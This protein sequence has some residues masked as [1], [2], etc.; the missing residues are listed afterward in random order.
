MAPTT[1]STD[2][3]DGH[4]SESGLNGA[5]NVNPAGNDA[6]KMNTEPVKSPQLIPKLTVVT[7]NQATPPTVETKLD[8]M[9]D[10]MNKLTET[11]NSVSLQFHAVKLEIVQLNNTVADIHKNQAD[12]AILEKK[13]NDIT[14][15]IEFN[16]ADRNA[17]KDHIKTIEQ[18][19]KAD[20]I[21]INQLKSNVQQ[22]PKVCECSKRL[23]RLE[24]EQKRK[25]ILITG[26]RERKGE[27]LKGLV[28]EILSNT[29]AQIDPYSIDQAVRVGHFNPKAPPRPILVKF[30]DLSTKEVI[31]SRKHLIKENPNC[32][33]VWLN[34]DLS[35]E[36]KKTRAEMRTLGNLAV[37][38][39][40]QVLL[41]GN[42]IVIDGVSYDKDSLDQLPPH[43]SLERAYTRDTPNGIGFHSKHSFLSSFYFAPFTF[44][45]MGYTCSEQAIQHIKA[46]THKHEGLAKQI[47]KETEP[48]EMKKLGDQITTTE[49]WKK[50]E[51]SLMGELVD[52]KFD[53]NPQLAKKL[54]DTKQAPLLEC[55]MSKHWGIGMTINHPDLRKKSFKPQGKNVL[56]HILEKKRED[57]RRSIPQQAHPPNTP[58]AGPPSHPHS[59]PTAA[60]S[61]TGTIPPPPPPPHP[62]PKQQGAGGTTTEIPNPPPRNKTKT[63]S[64]TQRNLQASSPNSTVQPIPDK[65]DNPLNYNLNPKA[66]PFKPV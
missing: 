18:R 41:R 63:R 51:N 50:S 44:N 38:M 58:Q 28:L 55:T 2:N 4:K 49:E 5:P 3:K 46:T 13:V 7:Q 42:N 65:V 14:E 35:E 10:Q 9:I 23:D 57:I 64:P 59:P 61:T 11:V 17:I 36:S 25:N 24:T 48:L 15:S 12:I 8:M 22:G 60:Q 34:D 56:G 1:R 20:H 47:L 16:D 62:T 27:N 26:V 39:G 30:L 66:L 43:L 45:K 37:D 6:S 31:M 32:K 21:Q 54:I 52:H 33:Y 29:K 40:H 19:Q 53:Q